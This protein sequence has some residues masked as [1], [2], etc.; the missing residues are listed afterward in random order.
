[1]NEYEVIDALSSLRGEVGVH[2]MNFIA[3][4]FGYLATAYFVGA[5]L[6]GFQISAINFLYIVFVPG[7][8]FGIYESS[9][10][11]RNIYIA[12]AETVTNAFGASESYIMIPI[13]APT[14]VTASWIVS[15]IF[16]HQIRKHASQNGITS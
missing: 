13:I 10:T 16:M 5:K 9:V 12:H 7:P 3:V 4:L 1:M 14:M 11:M 15:I 2:V 6:T 8:L